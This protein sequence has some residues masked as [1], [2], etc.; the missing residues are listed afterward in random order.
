MDYL[1]RLTDLRND[2]DVKQEEVAKVLNCKQSAISKY[3]KRRARMSV[4]DV[5]K[6]CSFYNVSADYVLGL[7]E[8]MPYP[9]R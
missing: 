1:D 8:N 7:P 2:R 5:A 3:E 4:E 9:Q 6:L